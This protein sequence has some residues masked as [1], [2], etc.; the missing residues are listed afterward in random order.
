[1][2]TA[3]REIAASFGITWD[4]SALEKGLQQ[5]EK[6]KKGLAVFGGFLAATGYAVARFAEGFENDAGA[7]EDTANALNLNTTE[8]QELEVAA[9]RA[10]LRTEQFRGSLLRFQQ[11]AEAAAQ[12]GSAQAQVFEK[13]G[14]KVKDAGGHVLGTGD[15]LTDLAEAFDKI[16]DPAQKAAYANELFG[17]QGA[18]LVT[19]LHSGAGGL[20]ELRGELG[21]LGGGL[22][23]EGVAAAGK[24]GDE[25]DR[26]RVATNSVRSGIAVVLLPP[27]T[28]LA[29]KV[30]DLMVGF[31][32]L[33]RE[34]SIIQTALLAL[35]GAAV[36]AAGVVLS[37]FSPL[38]LAMAPWALGL[39]AVFLILEDLVTL[40]RGGQSVIGEF[41]D[42]IFGVGAS[43]EFVNTL[44]EAF[45]GTKEM[46]KGITDGIE[47]ILEFF[48]NSHLVN[49]NRYRSVDESARHGF[50]TIEE[51]IGRRNE[52]DSGPRSVTE[53]AAQGQ[54]QTSHTLQTLLANARRAGLTVTP[55]L[56]AELQAV[57]LPARPTIPD[58]AARAP[59][60]PRVEQHNVNHFHIDGSKDPRTVAEEVVRLTE[61]RNA[62][63][64]ERAAAARTETPQAASE[65]T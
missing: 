58:P 65:G 56:R 35:A 27:L 3:L 5:V 45:R 57:A 59:A 29:E 33:S 42:A 48:G 61:R 20:E 52:G 15:L 34:T 19:I 10:G 13:L 39:A 37:A 9:T 4:G 36:Y 40:F 12:G 50:S 46:V 55:E 7:L 1:M 54:T 53:A 62:A 2:G 60:G 32:K 38:I 26:L 6:A 11:N 17:R 23:Q 25:F 24:L 28:W 63:Q 47:E 44:T 21:E 43:A 8:L 31:S 41:I 14:V 18:K 49:R 22:T 51:H 64:L 30:R 16:Q